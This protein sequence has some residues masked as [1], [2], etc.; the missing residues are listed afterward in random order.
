VVRGW[1]MVEMSGWR[2]WVGWVDYHWPVSNFVG[3]FQ[4]LLGVAGLCWGS[5]V[6]RLK[7]KLMVYM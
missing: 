7:M 4:A 5:A 1:L 2:S 6:I 3:F